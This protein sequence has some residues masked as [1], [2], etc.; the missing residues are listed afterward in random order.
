MSRLIKQLPSPDILI[1]QSAYTPKTK[2]NFMLYDQSN[3]IWKAVGMGAVAGMR[4]M[5]APALL[6]DELSKLPSAS[7]AHSPLHFLQSDAVASGLKLFAAT[8]LL[9]DKIPNVPDR[10]TP[11]SLAIRAI[12]G[13][14]V[15]ATIFTANKDSTSKGAIIGAAAA[16][17]GTFASFYLRKAIKKYTHLPDSLSGTIED[18]LMFGSGLAITKA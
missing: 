16:I 2:T 9:G 3:Y 4:A 1:R 7:L 10:I 12:S 13:A 17:A 6:S 14:V 5:S 15:G 11:P 8:E 18:V